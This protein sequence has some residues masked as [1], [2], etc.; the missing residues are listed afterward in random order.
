MENLKDA[1]TQPAKAGEGRGRRKG[2]GTNQKEKAGKKTTNQHQRTSKTSLMQDSR[3]RARQER[4]GAESLVRRDNRGS[5][6][7]I[8]RI[9]ERIDSKWISRFWLEKTA[10]EGEKHE[11][12][13]QDRGN[14]FWDLQR[15][16]SKRGKLKSPRGQRGRGVKRNPPRGEFEILQVK[17]GAKRLTSTLK[18]RGEAKEKGAKK[19]RGRHKRKK[20]Q[21]RKKEREV[22]R[23]LLGHVWNVRRG[24]RA[25]NMSTRQILT[26]SKREVKLKSIPKGTCSSPSIG[27]AIN[28]QELWN[29]E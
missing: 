2:K 4:R 18:T 8:H 5:D 22:H 10:P 3:R 20:D 6:K 12:K 7:T 23:G 13:G 26:N 17:K 25:L 16:S 21:G 29:S 27:G 1:R 14:R 19:R 9:G 11:Q 28:L 24:S 15:E